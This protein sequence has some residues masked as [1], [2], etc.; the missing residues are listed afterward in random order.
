ME[1]MWNINISAMGGTHPRGATSPTSYLL[2]SAH[3]S[4]LVWLAQK[5][6]FKHAPAGSSTAMW[7]RSCRYCSFPCSRLWDSFGVAPKTEVCGSYIPMQCMV[8]CKVLNL[9]KQ[10]FFPKGI[11]PSSSGRCW[12]KIQRVTWT[13]GLRL[14]VYTRIRGAKPCFLDD[15]EI[16]CV[17]FRETHTPGSNDIFCNTLELCKMI[18]LLLIWF[19]RLLLCFNVLF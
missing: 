1:V 3:L 12:Q 13:V 14:L 9:W 15:K 18:V 5:S 17:Q 7:R 6:P 16:G 19:S 11:N 10:F 4:L 8:G 2:D